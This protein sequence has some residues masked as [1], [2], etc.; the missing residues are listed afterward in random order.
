[1]FAPEE[2]AVV[3]D[4]PLYYDVG[5]SGAEQMAPRKEKKK[6][7]TALRASGGFGGAFTGGFQTRA[8]F[9]VAAARQ[10]TSW[11]LPTVVPTTDVP[12]RL[13]KVQTKMYPRCT[14][15]EASLGLHLNSNWKHQ[16]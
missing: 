13:A 8:L 6:G 11:Y 7:N 2:A 9:N 14:S 3:C 5:G 10:P 12:R 16:S 4:G 15:S 1:M